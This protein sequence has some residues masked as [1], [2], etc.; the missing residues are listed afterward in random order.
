MKTSVAMC[1]YNGE[2]FLNEQ[3][4]SILNQTAVVD[5]I[6]V[7][8]DNS[9]DSTVSILKSYQEKYPQ[10]FKI[11]IN[12][13]TLR[14]T[15][16]FEKAISLCENEIIFLSDQDDIWVDNKVEKIIEVFKNDEEISV[17]CTNG[18][19]IDDKSNLLDVISIWDGKRLITKKKYRFDYFMI[20]NLVDNFCTGATMALKKEMKKD[21]FPFP[22]IE[23]FH[24]DRWIALVAALGNKLYFLDEKLI[25]YR[26]HVSQQVGSV[27]YQNDDINKEL[28]RGYFA[29]DKEDKSFKEYKKLLRRFALAYQKNNGLLEQKLIRQ[30]YLENT[31][32][33]LK[34]R[35]S[36]YNKEMRDKYPFKSFFLKIADYFLQKRKL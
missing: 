9:T 1:T 19:G 11:Y 8:D 13:D 36:V 10:I 2:K 31:N 30:D 20:L 33:E 27:L 15:R 25:Y 3:L 7:C 29:I 5:E 22:I 14:S 24:H 32:K 35:F 28:I 17:V 26:K 34:R 12:E 21:I 18:Y 23:E 4:K 16:N 6:V